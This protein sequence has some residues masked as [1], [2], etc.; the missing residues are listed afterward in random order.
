M[1]LMRRIGPALLL[2]GFTGCATVADVRDQA[3]RDLHCAVA[4][5]HLT[6]TGEGSWDAHGCG[7]SAA[8]QVRSGQP[9]LVGTIN[10]DLSNPPPRLPNGL[11]D[12]GEVVQAMGRIKGKVGLCYDQYKV[13]GLAMVHVTV[14]DDGNI[15]SAPVLKDFAGTP[16]GSCIEQAVMKTRFAPF[17]GG[18]FVFD[19]PFFLR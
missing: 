17:T 8:Y 16:T 6:Q 9:M 18:P 10:P 19:Y 15:A 4:D 11:P 3:A 12:K 13:Q 14:L 1:R 5:V 7:Q 2:L